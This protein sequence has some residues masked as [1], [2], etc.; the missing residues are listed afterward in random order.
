MN[1]LRKMMIM[2]VVLSLLNLSFPQTIYAL[3]STMFAQANGA[4]IT[5]HAPEILAA[6]EVEIP[7]ETVTTEGK[8]IS[9]WWWILGGAAVVGGIAAAAGGGGGGGGGGDDTPAATTG[10]VTVTW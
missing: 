9:K 10:D 6:Q 2:T 7:G 8:K 1:I 4:G 5:E 3:R